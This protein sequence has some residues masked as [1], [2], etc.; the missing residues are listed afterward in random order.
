MGGWGGFF[1]AIRRR[2]YKLPGKTW[3]ATIVALVY[4]FSPV[5]FIPELIL[6][7]LLGPVGAVGGLADDLAI[8]GVAFGMLVREKKRWEAQ[9]GG[10]AASSKDDTDIIDVES[11]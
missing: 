8:L 3:A 6:V 4:V 7:P 5:D 1:K 10:K 9:I 2:E 11:Y